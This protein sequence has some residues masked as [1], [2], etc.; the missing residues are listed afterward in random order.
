MSNEFTGIS[1]PFRIGVKGGVVMSSTSPTDVTHI[2]ESMQQILGTRPMERSME[3]HIKSGLVSDIFMISGD[4]SAKSLVDYQI[5]EALRTL[6]DR[7]DVKS[8]DI[9]F[10]DEYVIATIYFEVLAYNT[11]YNYDFKVGEMNG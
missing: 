8:I 11:V 9:V 5:R 7:I 4:D 6:E 10:K 1:F 3:Y 2:I